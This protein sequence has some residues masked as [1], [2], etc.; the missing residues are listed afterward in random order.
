MGGT[1][2]MEEGLEQDFNP[3]DENVEERGSEQVNEGK[4]RNL[5]ISKTVSATGRAT[6]SCHGTSLS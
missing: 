3:L 5:R 1:D 6:A 4:F 2:A